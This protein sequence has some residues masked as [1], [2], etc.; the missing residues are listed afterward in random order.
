[1]RKDMR[2]TKEA[3]LKTENQALLIQTQTM[4]FNVKRLQ[5]YIIELKEKLQVQVKTNLASSD[6][7]E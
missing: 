5:D 1:M 4:Q 7:V 6:N 2:N 3:E